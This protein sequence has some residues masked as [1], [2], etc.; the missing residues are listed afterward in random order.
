MKLIPIPSK[1]VHYPSNGVG[2]DLIVGDIHGCFDQL[3][4]ALRAI[5]FNYTCDR[6]FS[7]GDVI[8]RGSQSFDCA[9]LI[10][11]HWFYPVQGN[12]EQMMWY[13]LLYQNN[14]YINIWI[15]NGGLW[16]R[17][18]DS[19]L[20]KDIAYLQQKLPLVISV[21]EGDSRFNIVHAELIKKSN[22]LVTNADIDNWTFSED[23]EESM[24]WGRAIARGWNKSASDVKRHQSEELSKTYVGHTAF[25]PRPVQIEQQVFLDTGC[26]SGL[27]PKRLDTRDLYP[28]TIASPQE[29]V[30][31]CYCTLWKKIIKVPYHATGNSK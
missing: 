1:H 8:D 7:V 19:Q 13:S 26:V 20:L 25:K 3:M 12:H 29:E 10:Y 22:T 4:S 17:Q 15:Q 2:R 23:E 5:D 21:G 24:V 30:Y 28:L 18:E 6:L 16:F 31:Y 11:E 27:S 9:D 14:A